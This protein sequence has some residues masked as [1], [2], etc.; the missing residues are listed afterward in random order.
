[1]ER[2]GGGCVKGAA[3]RVFRSIATLLIAAALLRVP[4][5]ASAAVVPL[6]DHHQ[7]LFSPEVAR[8][9][10]PDSSWG[11]I[12]AGDL[13]AFLGSAGIRRAVV[14]SVAYLWGSP[15]RNLADE[16]ASVRAENDW[17]AGQ[18]ASAPRRLVGFCSVNPLKPYALAEIERCARN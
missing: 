13:V 1:M 11:G 5:S 10:R 12:S 16:Y 17:T 18:V 14:L 2:P 4:V 9:L 15:G 7:H 6:V 3:P 8:L